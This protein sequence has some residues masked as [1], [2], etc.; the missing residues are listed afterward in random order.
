VTIREWLATRTPVAPAALTE[1][2]LAILGTRADAPTDRAAEALLD[3]AQS[4]LRRLL[5]QRQFARD[6]ALDL[7]AVDAL[8]TFAYEH[9]AERAG[10]SADLDALTR[11]GVAAVAPLAAHG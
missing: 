9:G 6:G 11:R 4:E 2:M 1:R 10:T 3:A 8:M 5:E 7:L